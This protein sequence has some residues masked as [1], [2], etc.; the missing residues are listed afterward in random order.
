MDEIK[1]SISAILYERTTS[2]F[3]GTF[4]FSW[5]IWNWK[6]PYLTIF[7]SENK[8][9]DNKIN[10]IIKNY[11]SLCNLLIYPLI[12]TII[13]LTVI[14]FVSNGAY[15]LS[16]KFENWKIKQKNLIED[17]QLLTVE[18][19]IELRE[20]IRKQ[21][22]RFINLLTNKNSEIEVL[23]KRISELSA[24]E[25]LSRENDDSE[26]KSLAER[27]NNNKSEMKIFD[28]VT[29][30]IHSNLKIQSS[31]EVMKIIS[32]LESHDIIHKP[33]GLFKFTDNGKKLLKYLS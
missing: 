15:W 32:L 23:N 3:F 2:P 26:I 25:I 11:D 31:D 12:S 14:P 18:Q 27:F 21:E 8:L 5:L 28:Y 7:I 13:L 6:I 29:K 16:L 17:K 19:S 30:C 1:K 33:E 24:T 4:I 22:E 10:Y 9:P 20:Q